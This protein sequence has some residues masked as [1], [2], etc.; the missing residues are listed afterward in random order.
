MLWVSSQASCFPPSTPLSWWSAAS[1]STP[2]PTERLSHKKI[3]GGTYISTLLIIS[4]KDKRGVR[5]SWDVRLEVVGLRCNI[6]KIFNLILPQG[7]YFLDIHISISTYQNVQNWYA[8]L[9]TKNTEHIWR[10][11]SCTKN[12][13]LQKLR[14]TKLKPSFT[15][16][17]SQSQEDKKWNLKKWWIIN[18]LPYIKVF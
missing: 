4:H 16:W 7:V 6:L 14:K 9:L 13:W 15:V 1:G 11:L 10:R 5:F 17:S 12:A 2:A 18:V 3:K 8:F